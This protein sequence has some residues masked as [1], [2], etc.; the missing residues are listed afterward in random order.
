MEAEI[1][2]TLG[3]KIARLRK[4]RGWTQGEL[5]EKIFVHPR[6]VTRLER[7]KMKPSEATLARLVEVFG[8]QPEDIMPAQNEAR[9]PDL[10]DQLSEIAR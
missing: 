1:G 2:S 6:H 10:E 4:Q 7:N 9:L 3:D 5:A 8:I